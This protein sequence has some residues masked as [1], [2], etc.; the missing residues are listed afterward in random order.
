MEFIFSVTK[1]LQ[2]TLEILTTFDHL[3]EVLQD[4][5]SHFPE[6][7]HG[8]IQSIFELATVTLW[9]LGFRSKA[10]YSVQVCGMI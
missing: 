9:N 1:T 8:I 10:V 7:A 6:T 2:E 3:K 4:I 5:F